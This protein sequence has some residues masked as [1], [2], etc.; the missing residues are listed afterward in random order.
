M[1][2]LARAPERLAPV[3]AE[4]LAIVR[5]LA[6]PVELGACDRLPEPDLVLD[7]L[8]GYGQRGD[9]H[10]LAA[11]LIDWSAG[12]RVL[13][14]DVPSGLE[15]ATGSQGRPT[16]AAEATMTLALP[17]SAL[18]APEALATVGRLFLA[19]ISVPALVYE[20]LGL[21]YR[22]PFGPASVVELGSRPPLLA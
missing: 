3:T 21:R 5:G 20:R 19:D 11:E 13:S 12:R 17:K 8:L 16:V 4:Q 2:A 22:T 6:I 15:L 18:A 1:V 10:G 14:L 7:A 9:P